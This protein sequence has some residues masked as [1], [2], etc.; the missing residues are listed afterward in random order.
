MTRGRFAEAAEAFIRIMP[1][2][3]EEV[4]RLTSNAG[5]KS[6]ADAAAQSEAPGMAIL[7]SRPYRAGPCW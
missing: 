7:F 1:Q 4:L 3:Q 2:Q 6:F 5:K